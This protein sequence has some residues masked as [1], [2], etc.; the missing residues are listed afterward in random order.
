MFVEIK[1]ALIGMKM[2]AT[3]KFGSARTRLMGQRSS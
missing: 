2:S 1:H 3:E